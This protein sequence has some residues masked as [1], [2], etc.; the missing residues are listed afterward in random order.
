MLFNFSKKIEQSQNGFRPISKGCEPARY[1][2]VQT[3]E[4]NAKERVHPADAEYK[5]FFL[6]RLSKRANYTA[7]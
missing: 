4:S 5:R 6:I 3:A 7:F 1:R 2:F